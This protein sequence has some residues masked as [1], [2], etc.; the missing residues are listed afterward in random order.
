MNHSGYW[1]R[2]LIT[3]I[4]PLA[5]LIPLQMPLAEFF[6]LGVFDSWAVSFVFAFLFKKLLCSLKGDVKK[7]IYGFE[8]VRHSFLAA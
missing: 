3:V 4:Q 8:A 1:V 7:M 6:G 2:P 5:L